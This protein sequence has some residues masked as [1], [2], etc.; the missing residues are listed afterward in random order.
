MPTSVN[1]IQSYYCGS[2][3]QSS[4]MDSISSA[5]GCPYPVGIKFFIIHICSINISVLKIILPY[6]PW[7]LSLLP[8]ISASYTLFTNHSGYLFK[9]F[10]LLTRILFTFSST[11]SC[12]SSISTFLTLSII[13]FFAIF[14]NLILSFHIMWVY[15]IEFLWLI[16][17]SCTISMSFVTLWCHSTFCLHFTHETF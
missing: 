7:S 13:V 10:L 12:F 16:P 5:E 3:N 1:L 4:N 9:A 2:S 6:I 14:L 11:P 17:I 15:C 8:C